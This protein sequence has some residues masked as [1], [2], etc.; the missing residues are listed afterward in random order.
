MKMTNL[1]DS[2]SAAAA[3]VFAAAID[4]DVACRAVPL[5]TADEERRLPLTRALRLRRGE[6]APPT[7]ILMKTIPM[8][9][10][11]R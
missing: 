8:T 9:M 1:A 7:T 2:V 3:F 11:R 10:T 5:A 6:K 4:R